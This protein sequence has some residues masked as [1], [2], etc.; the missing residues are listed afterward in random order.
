M[1]EE[2]PAGCSSE[3]KAEEP[4]LAGGSCINAKVVTWVETPSLR[5]PSLTVR[6][7]D[8][9]YETGLQWEKFHLLLWDSEVSI[10]RD[11]LNH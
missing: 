5:S 1:P 3:P 8:I 6:P 9:S 10:R 7:R 4:P 2:S 11:K